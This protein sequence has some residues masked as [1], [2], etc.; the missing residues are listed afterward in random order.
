M[1]DVW[2]AFLEKEISLIE[3]LLTED[4]KVA[5][6]FPLKTREKNRLQKIQS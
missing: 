6:K 1:R 4:H 2:V 5:F 3:M